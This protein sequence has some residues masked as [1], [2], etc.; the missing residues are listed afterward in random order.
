MKLVTSTEANRDFSKLL[1]EVQRGEQVRITSRGRP[2]ATMVPVR[3]RDDTRELARQQLLE[4][5]NA[6]ATSGHRDWT[7]EDLYE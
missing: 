3:Q 7:R 5:L 1:R 6:R 4:R 2:I